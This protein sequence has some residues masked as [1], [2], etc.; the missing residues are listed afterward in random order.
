MNHPTMTGGLNPLLTEEQIQM[1]SNNRQSHAQN[2]LVNNEEI[3][4]LGMP[5]MNFGEKPKAENR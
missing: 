4:P 5:T 2:V 3:E 1:M